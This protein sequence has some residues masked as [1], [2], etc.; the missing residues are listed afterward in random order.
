M[1]KEKLLI[2]LDIGTDSVGWAATNENFELKRIK[3]KTA[4]GARLFEKANNAQDRRMKRTT[5]R[6]NARR[7]YRIFLLSQLLGETLKQ[8]DPD[9]LVRLA[10]SSF[11]LEHKKGMPSTTIFP[12]RE[13]EVAFY[14]R[15][16]TIWHL[17]KELLNPNSDAYNDIRLVYLALHHIIKYRGNFLK[18]GSFET[19][20]FDDQIIVDLNESLNAILRGELEEETEE[21][22]FLP[23]TSKEKIISILENGNLNARDKKKELLALFDLKG[24]EEIKP[25]VDM[26]VSLLAGG[27]FDFA[28]L[29][30]DYE[31]YSVKFDNAFEEKIP[32]IEERLGD[33][34]GVLLAAKQI[35]DF[36]QLKDLLR[37]N[38]CLS[39]A[40]VVVYEQ[41]KQMLQALKAI[42]KEIDKKHGLQGDESIY[43]KIFKDKK[44]KDNYAA[45]VRVDSEERNTDPHAFNAYLKK[46]LE[47]FFAEYS[48]NRTFKEIWY[49][50]ERDQ[51]L[52]TIANL[53]TSLIPHQ[54]HEQELNT[55]LENASRRIP[56]IGDCAEKIKQLFL[57]RVPYYFGP[58]ND[59]SPYS[60]VIRLHNETITPWNMEQSVDVAATR[61]KFM[62][63]LT[64]SCTYLLGE[65]DVLPI[66]SIAYQKYVILNR[67]NG[68]R[69][70]GQLI[71]QDVKAALYHYILGRK[72]TT[73][74]QMEKFLQRNYD[75]Y[76][77]DKAAI[78]GL[79]EAD[80]FVSDSYTLFLKFFN[81]QSLSHEQEEIAERIIKALTLYTDYPADAFDYIND[82]ILK[83]DKAHRNLL[84]SK[85]FKG[86]GRLSKAFL[87]DMK[88]SDDLGVFH[89]IL[90]VLEE[91][92]MTLNQIL[93]NE[94]LGFGKE[95]DR[96][97][98]EFT[99]DKTPDEVVAQI[100]G[101][102]PPDRR[103]PTLQA[104]RIVD[105]IVS[106]SK[107]EPEF[108]SIEVTRHDEKEKKMRDDRYK[109]L[110][111]FLRALQQDAEIAAQAKAAKECLETQFQDDVRKLKLKGTA[112]YLYF[113]QAG[114]D[115]YTGKPIDILDVLNSDK[116]DIDHIVPQHL[117]K[118]DSLDNKVLV[119]RTY[120]QR[121]KGGQYPIPEQI[122]CQEDIVK[123]WKLLY[124]HGGLSSK[125]YN[126]LIR[127]NEVTQ[128]ELNGFV[129]AQLNVVNVS[130]IAIKQVLSVKYPKAKLVF[131]KATFPSELRKQYGIAKLREL[132]DTH[133]A[134]DAYLNIVAGVTLY[135]E[136]SKDYI[137]GK[138]AQKEAEE[139]DKT[140]NMAKRLL[141]LL[142][143]RRQKDLV[144]KNCCERHDFLSTHRLAY[145]EAAFYNQTLYGKEKNS[146]VPIHTE[147]YMADTSLYGGYSGL[148]ARYFVIAEIQ[149]KKPRRQLVDVP[150]LWDELYQGDEL[151]EHLKERVN[152]KAGETVS[153]DLNRRIATGQKVLID[154]CAY[155]LKHED[156][157][158]L[159]LYPVSQIF[160]PKE[161]ERYLS[162]AQKNIDEFKNCDGESYTFVMDKKEQHELVVSKTKNREILNTL[163]EIGSSKRYVVYPNVANLANNEAGS[164]MKLTLAEQI[165]R[166]IYIIRLFTKNILGPAKP[167]RKSKTG[168]LEMKPVA[169]YESVTGLR[170]YKKVL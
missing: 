64:A 80:T 119:E 116:Y 1:E 42:A 8:K 4:W 10:N 32:E 169:V 16:P 110:N 133:H 129:N 28:K 162:F 46:T 138:N 163:I 58:L 131:S 168:F 50:I 23:L 156:I 63:S 37:G 65:S 27:S 29:G 33:N 130:N 13:E 124:R 123:L 76:Q 113:K 52:L 87:V 103:R 25:F 105:E 144:I 115:L 21:Q 19:N 67:L 73:I 83:L 36:N 157:R 136:Y 79:N 26:F 102:L 127:P 99:G 55:I 77:K 85:R 146:L 165:N 7:K 94:K 107:Q 72:N 90:S 92:V 141:D 101:E 153:I 31:K 170:S 56:A 147:G 158:T 161:T 106:L 109:E 53:S 82:N 45:F 155:I 91:Q 137:L 17:R 84:S 74:G 14:K 93:F 57:F 121:I 149:G 59:R 35:Y 86:W 34:F 111:N 134:V 100:I 44:N 18:V 78:S 47:P 66:D 24:Q 15:F 128:D 118:D 96:R 5:R 75:V 135:K 166:L 81:V 20:R 151:V 70:N 117:I 6:R 98:R 167:L 9:F 142:R 120:N 62:K 104:L 88:V 132:N 30:E 54:L 71:D 48:S 41:H 145:V 114:L 40:F 68:V 12:Y 69:I 61:E 148:A 143:I 22:E 39:D 11:V 140:Y 126:N 154:G 97:N 38:E 122:R 152:S 159:M 3:G 150:L 95:I 112:I 108:I 164:F 60:N 139:G 160:L 89:S 49:L 2:G 43:F 51:A 125:K